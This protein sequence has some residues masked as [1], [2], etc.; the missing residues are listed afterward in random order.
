MERLDSAAAAVHW[1]LLKIDRHGRVLHAEG[2]LPALRGAL[3]FSASG[4][5]LPDLL[6]GTNVPWQPPLA[7]V[8]EHSQPFD[9]LLSPR[10][11]GEARTHAGLLLSAI[12][13]RSAHGGVDHAW[14]LLRPAL[15]AEHR[16]CASASTAPSTDAF[17]LIAN[18]SAEGRLIAVQR[19]PSLG[20]DEDPAVL[21]GADVRTLP[22]WQHDATL[23][24]WLT[25]ALVRAA[26][27]EQVRARMDVHLNATQPLLLDFAISPGSAGDPSLL[28]FSV[29]GHTV[30]HA[31]DGLLQLSMAQFRSAFEASP[32]GMALVEPPGVLTLVNPA[33]CRLFRYLPEQLAQA[34]LDRLIPQTIRSVH[35]DW[36]TSYFRAP[37][38]RPM[39]PKRS[40]RGVRSD[41]EEIDLEVSLNPVARADPQ[42]VLITVTDITERLRTQKALES[43]LREKTV[44]LNEVHHRVKNNLQ[45]IASLLRLQS[46]HVEPAARIA[47][48]DSMARV[49]SMGLIHQLLYES[50]DMG[51]LDLGQF[52]KRL[53][54]LVRETGLSL[55]QRVRVEV[56]IDPLPVL[57]GLA[58]AVPCGLLVNELMT[59]AMKHAFPGERHGCI[60]VSLRRAADSSVLIGV[61]DDGI[62]MPE[63]D[64]APPSPTL[65]LRLLPLLADQLGARLLRLDPTGGGVGYEF[66][67]C[68]E[69]TGA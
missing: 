46:R 20:P 62:G 10:T 16:T 61:N 14:L 3:G 49:R 23:R 4:D 54:A 43:G 50:Q 35:G 38:A 12:P 68:I 65:G 2:D 56:E 44:L 30:G 6:P 66:E 17:V 60:R 47:L 11:Q 48:Q 33:F 64:S 57:I 58:Q 13:A 51:H 24:V 32:D 26:S 7:G 9:L 40:V 39:A 63:A 8:F 67:F 22:W 42:Q 5:V 36:M 15:P 29:T 53:I 55:M 18:A 41:G 69:E 21:A 28:L 45:V 1:G 37:H 25:E 59:N 34:P 19:A 27:G 52:L 31:H